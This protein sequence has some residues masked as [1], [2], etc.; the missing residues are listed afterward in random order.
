MHIKQII[1]EGFKTYKDRTV[2][3]N[4][5]PGANA[6]VGP[7]GSG[8]SNIFAGKCLCPRKTSTSALSFPLPT[9]SRRALPS[10]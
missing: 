6:I 4:L 3:D 1:V 10:H 9:R 2:I 8:K 7:N 5:S